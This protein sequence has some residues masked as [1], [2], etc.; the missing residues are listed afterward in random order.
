MTLFYVNSVSVE[1]YQLDF[2]CKPGNEISSSCDLH[3][4]GEVSHLAFKP[5]W[6]CAVCG[7]LTNRVGLVYIGYI[8]IYV[9]Y[10]LRTCIYMLKDQVTKDETLDL[11]VE[12]VL[13]APCELSITAT[14]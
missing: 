3:L 13:S 7:Q 9:C 8:N 10:S 11:F 2:D 6:T 14:S 12:S 4:Q 5:C 1:P